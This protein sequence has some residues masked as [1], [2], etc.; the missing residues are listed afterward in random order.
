MPPLP[1]SRRGQDNVKPD[2]MV[3]LSRRLAQNAYDK[4]SNPSGIVDIG[5]AKN[6]LMLD[7]LQ[8]WL[9]KYDDSRDKAECKSALS[10]GSNQ[11]W[12]GA[13]QLNLPS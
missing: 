1:P 3:D 5:S 2:Q 7:E 8:T 9:A 10:A 13:D 4:K 6:E 11:P 12:P